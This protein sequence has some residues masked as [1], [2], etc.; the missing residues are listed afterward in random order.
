MAYHHT[1]AAYF[2]VVL[3]V[4]SL[5]VNWCNWFT[6]V[7]APLQAKW[8]LACKLTNMYSALSLQVVVVHCETQTLLDTVTGTHWLYPRSSKVE[9]ETLLATIRV[10]SCSQEAIFW[11]KHLRLKLVL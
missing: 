9:T 1:M 5:G 6:H 7:T 10:W 4:S 11:T 8:Y 3:F 2:A